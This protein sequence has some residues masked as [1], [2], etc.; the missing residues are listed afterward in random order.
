MDIL[1]TIGPATEKLIHE[2]LT[3]QTFQGFPIWLRVIWYV[4]AVL[5]VFVFLYGV[6]R[7]VQRYRRQSNRSGLP[8]WRELPKRV[9]SGL[10]LV[11]EHRT[12]AKRAR[13]AGFAHAAVFYGWLALFAAT[14][15]LAFDGDFL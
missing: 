1:A 14:V 9:L 12:I 4:L 7:P 5:S 2:G 13:A 10:A 11:S 15:I 3:R 8:S 6:W